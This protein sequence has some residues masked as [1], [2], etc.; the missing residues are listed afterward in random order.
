[1]IGCVTHIPVP[2]A[3]MEAICRAFGV[4]AETVERWCREGAPIVAGK[5][6]KANICAAELMQLQAWVEKRGEWCGDS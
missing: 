2:L 3:G 6:G 5:V 4:T 1:M